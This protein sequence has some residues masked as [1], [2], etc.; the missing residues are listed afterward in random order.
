MSSVMEWHPKQ[1]KLNMQPGA[2]WDPYVSF[3]NSSLHYSLPSFI[4]LPTPI[5]STSVFA[6]ISFLGYSAQK[7]GL[8]SLGLFFM[9]LGLESAL[10]LKGR[11]ALKFIFLFSLIRDHM[12]TL[13]TLQYLKSAASFPPLCSR[14][15]TLVRSPKSSLDSV[16]LQYNI[17]FLLFGEI[18]LGL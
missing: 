3:S 11:A 5:P 16:V 18:F 4:L 17:K 9:Y 14:G 7:T 12:S 10:R 6:E 2:Q 1:I 15:A 8:G 13:P